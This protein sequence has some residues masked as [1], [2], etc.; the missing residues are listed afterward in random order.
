MTNRTKALIAS[1]FLAS[2]VATGLGISYNVS[3]EPAAVAQ[4]DSF[5]KDAGFLTVLRG[6]NV[7]YTSDADAI[8]MGHRV[9]SALRDEHVNMWIEGTRL[10]TLGYTGDEASTIVT[11]SIAFYAPEF[12]PLVGSEN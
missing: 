7:G 3:H 12:G 5:D 11:A 1:L 10:V 9:A 2:A 4:T 8:E 6:K